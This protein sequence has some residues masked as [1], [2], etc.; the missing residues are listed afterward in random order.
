MVFESIK[1]KNFNLFSEIYII[2]ALVLVLFTSL[3][4]NKPIVFQ[5]SV[6]SKKTCLENP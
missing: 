2:I 1:T 6:Y 3:A 4:K 5:P